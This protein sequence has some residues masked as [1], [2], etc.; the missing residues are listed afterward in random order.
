MVLCHSFASK[1][2]KS[3][4]SATR[5]KMAYLCEVSTLPDEIRALPYI[6]DEHVVPVVVAVVPVSTISTAEHDAAQLPDK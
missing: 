4:T 1:T 6:D 2:K 5:T 3:P